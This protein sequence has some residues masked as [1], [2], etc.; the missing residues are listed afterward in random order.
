MR[1]THIRKEINL[2]TPFQA[3]E[4]PTKKPKLANSPP[5]ESDFRKTGMKGL[6]FGELVGFKYEFEF[7]S[8]RTY[9]RDQ[10]IT[11]AHV[12]EVVPKRITPMP[13]MKG[14]TFISCKL[15]AVFR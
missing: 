6:V 13:V 1:Q 9:Y 11:S 2:I 12:A 4:N 14:Q 15:E 5:S 7:S 3:L 8:I 10:F